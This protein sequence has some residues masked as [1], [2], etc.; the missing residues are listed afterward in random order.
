MTPL[1]LLGPPPGSCD[2]HV[3]VFLPALFPYAAERSYTPPE[4]GLA[5]L[6]AHLAR[7]GMQRVVL[8]QPSCYG[9]HN[10]ALLH[11]LGEL[12][13]HRA[14]GVA[15]VDTDRVDEPAL[16]RLHAAGIRG[17]RLN[18]SV[19]AHADLRQV[20]QMLQR[21]AARLATRCWHLQVHA[22]PAMLE[23]LLPVLAGLPVPVVLDHFGGTA[24]TATTTLALLRQPHVWLKLSAPY[25][26]S[27]QDG[28]ADLR[29]LVEQCLATAPGRLLWGSDWPHT[30]GAGARTADPLAI[31][32]FRETDAHASLAQLAGW[33]P[34]ATALHRILVDNPAALYGF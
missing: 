4:A 7:C 25:R 10:D 6:Q 29:P 8:V 27:R 18:L 5:A 12:G 26:A 22:G 21:A 33:L 19:L 24:A 9:L 16:H 15:V 32:P 17:V 2:S 31:E 11:A 14:R 34:D 13:N 23:G 20:G 28:Q 3:H 30:G 1:S